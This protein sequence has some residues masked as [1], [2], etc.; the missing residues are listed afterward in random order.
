M[1]KLYHYKLRVTMAKHNVQFTK[2]NEYYTPKE[3]VKQ[4]GDFDYDPATTKEKAEEFG[5]KNYDTIDTDGLSKEWN[6]KKIWINPP[7]TIKHLFLQKAVDTFK[8]YHN[9]ILILV[10]IE[11]LTTRRFH[12]IMKGVGFTMFLPNGR[13]K[14]ESGLGKKSSS[15]AFGSVVIQ[16]GNLTNLYKD[17]EESDI[18]RINMI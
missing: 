14:F 4:F 5:V 6:Y 3:F 13:V 12:T 1:D 8:K 7:F 15:P 9:Y 18:K 16:I 17:N 11:F 2:D 10:P